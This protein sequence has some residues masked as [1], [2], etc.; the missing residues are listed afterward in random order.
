M[1]ENGEGGSEHGEKNKVSNHWRMRIQMN[2]GITV[3]FLGFTKYPFK[4]CSHKFSP[5]L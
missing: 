1:D 3:G 5:D 2:S 4:I